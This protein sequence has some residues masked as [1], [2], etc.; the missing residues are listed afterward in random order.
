[1][2]A[3]PA[4][5]VAAQPTAPANITVTVIGPNLELING[6]GSNMTL[7]WTGKE[8]VLIDT[9][10]PQ[11]T[12]KI[13]EELHVRN[14]SGRLM[15]INTHWHFDHVGSNASLSGPATVILA[16]TEAA[17]R[18]AIGGDADI[19][20]HHLHADPVARSGLPRR[21]Y[22]VST[23]LRVGDEEIL[24]LHPPRAHTDGDSLVKWTKANVLNMGDVYVG[25]D[26]PLLDVRAGTSLE[27]EISAIDMAL[28]ICDG[29]TV[30]IPGHGTPAT[31]QDLTEFRDRLKA[32][33][34][35]LRQAI[36]DGKSLDQ[37]QAMRLADGWKQTQTFFNADDF[38]VMAYRSYS[39]SSN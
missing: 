7:G 13:I 11:T 6:N 24:L 35:P 31:C 20:R 5:G 10:Y 39:K 22:D 23:S 38:I 19:G 16:Q 21:V 2:L 33:A 37:V 28:G 36:A 30:V 12:Q 1:M 3:L 32:V 34:T 9:G 8:A 17:K 18:M 26:F 15:V 27:G 29:K 4:M 25:G 14:P